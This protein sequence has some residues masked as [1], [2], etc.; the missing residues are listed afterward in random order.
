MGETY[1]GWTDKLLGALGAP[2][3]VGTRAAIY[4]IIAAEETEF[5]WN[6]LAISG[7]GTGQNSA[8]V[9]NFPSELAGIAAT[10][11]F[12]N[13]PGPQDYPGRIVAPLRANLGTNAIQ[14]FGATGA[15]GGDFPN[16][17][18]TF[19][20]AVA[21]PAQYDNRLLP[22]DPS[23]T[24]SREGAV[25][26]NAVPGEGVIADIGGAVGKLS[27]LSGIDAIGAFFNA[28]SFLTKAH[29]WVRIGFVAFGLILIVAAWGIISGDISDI[30]DVAKTVG[31][32][33]AVA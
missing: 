28:I 9:G 11:A 23:N 29:S 14:G 8:G 5:H 27:P 20:S 22:A 32:V 33:A 18:N 13:T 16:A 31:K 19:Q 7:A 1:K 3:S 4:A 21:N 26:P 6:P 24:A 2:S 30:I 15:W 10:V 25:T 17:Y 12:L